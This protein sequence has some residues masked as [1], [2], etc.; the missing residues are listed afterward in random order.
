MDYQIKLNDNEIA[1]V[2]AALDGRAYQLRLE[3]PRLSRHA[4]RTANRVCEQRQQQRADHWHL[5]PC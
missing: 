2:L 3:Q 1:V 4:K 5:T